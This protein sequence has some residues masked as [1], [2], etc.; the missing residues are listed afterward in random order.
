[1]RVA[2]HAVSSRDGR[3]RQWRVAV[4]FGDLRA[5]LAASDPMWDHLTSHE[6]VRVVLLPIERID[7]D[8]GSGS[9]KITFAPAGVRTLA[10]EAGQ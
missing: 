3:P 9:S 8:G 7:Y 1:V 10:A 2:H 6:R 4:V 5:A